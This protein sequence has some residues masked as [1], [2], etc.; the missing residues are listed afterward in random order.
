MTTVRLVVNGV[1]VTREVEDRM[2]L[3][4]LLH[5]TLGLTDVRVGCDTS[6]CGACLVRVDGEVVKA[7]TVLAVQAQGASVVT[8]AGADAGPDVGTG[9]RHGSSRFGDAAAVLPAELFECGFCRAGVVLAVGE[10]LTRAATDGTAVDETRV[11][12]YLE[13]VL[14]RCAT[15]DHVVDAV[16]GR[17]A[18]R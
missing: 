2:L 17:E 14:C 10:L 8:L 7:C 16:L 12:S 15:Y 13:G 5:D 3:V 18:S 1:P 4:H 11:R 9:E 6:N